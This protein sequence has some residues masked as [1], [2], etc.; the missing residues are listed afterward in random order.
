VLAREPPVLWKKLDE[1]DQRIGL[2]RKT[3]TRLYRASVSPE[4]LVSFQKVAEF[5]QEHRGEINALS[6]DPVV[7]PVVELL[8][9]EE[10]R[11]GERRESV[12]RHLV[13]RWFS[14]RRQHRSA[15]RQVMFGLFEAG[16]STIAELRQPGAKPPGAPKRLSVP[17]RE[18]LL[19]T[20]RP[21]DLCVTRHDDALSNLFLP[22]FWPH[23]TLYLGSVEERAE[24]DV[25]VS[26]EKEAWAA[27]PFR[28]LE[29]RKD[30]V[31]FRP[32][33]ETLAVDAC[34]VLRPPLEKADLARAIAR[35]MEQ[36]GKLDDFLFDFRSS[37]RLACTEVIYREFHG[38]GLVA[39][40]LKEVSGRK[41]LPAEDLLDQA[42]ACGFTIRA[43][44]GLEGD[45]VLFGAAAE[46]VFRAT[47]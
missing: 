46:R 45:S 11:I 33:E 21:G 4:S 23:A 2:P 20:L 24:L 31:R 27:G 44:T 9:G 40:R 29:S 5:Y 43:T 1:E 38:I 34:V 14:F 36:E 26:P 7:G 35:A 42:L 17:V 32:A 8:I 37:D 15:R 18:E 22:G 13:Y 47:R 25:A 3:F 6:S 10:A 19:A 28:F 16:G 12:K 39:F 30:G 41:C